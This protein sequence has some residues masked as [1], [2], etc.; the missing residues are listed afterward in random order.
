MFINSPQTGPDETGPAGIQPSI[1]CRCN[2]NQ[3]IHGPFRSRQIASG[4]CRLAAKNGRKHEV[5]FRSSVG[6]GLIC[7]L[8]R[9]ECRGRMRPWLASRSLRRLPTQSRRRLRGP[10]GCG[11]TPGCRG[12]ARSRLPLWFRL[13]LRTLPPGLSVMIWDYR[14]AP[15]R[16]GFLFVRADG[17]AICSSR[18]RRRIPAPCRRSGAGRRTSLWRRPESA[19][20]RKSSPVLPPP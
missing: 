16:R 11:G 8:Q 7:E 13:G 6:R 3:D 10:S 4:P 12:A 17:H 5:P 20:S 14:K 9:G 1:C 19:A 15:L 2:G 18:F